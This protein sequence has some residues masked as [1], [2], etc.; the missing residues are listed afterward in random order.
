MV[1]QWTNDPIKK[2]LA[3]GEQT[4]REAEG[5]SEKEDV[6]KALMGDVRLHLK[7]HQTYTDEQL[8]KVSYH[9]P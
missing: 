8:A 3:N 1:Y 5:T 6:V 9:V 2:V 4:Y 7:P